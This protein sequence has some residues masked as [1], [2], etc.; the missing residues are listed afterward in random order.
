[1]ASGNELMAA[2][3]WSSLTTGLFHVTANNPKYHGRRPL[4]SFKHHLH[5]VR[6]GV[7]LTGRNTTGSPWS[8]GR[9]TARAPSPPIGSIIDDDRLQTTTT[10]AREQNN[11]GPLG[12]PVIS[13]HM[14]G[15]STISKQSEL[16]QH[17]IC[18]ALYNGIIS[19]ALGMVRVNVRSHSFTCRPCLST[20]GMSHPVSTLKPQ[21][22]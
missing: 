18:I 12:G 14:L 13:Q 6:H 1:M 17:D 20:N 5:K 16:S 9:L 10:V 21:S 15:K 4:A 19:K 11:A 3:E 8:I 2:H 7:A 22:T